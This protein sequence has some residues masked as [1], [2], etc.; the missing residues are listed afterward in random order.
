MLLEHENRELATRQVRRI[1]DTL[2]KVRKISRDSQ[3]MLRPVL[4]T[5]P[6]P[7]IPI[8]IVDSSLPSPLS[9]QRVHEVSPPYSRADTRRERDDS[10]DKFFIPE[11]QSSSIVSEVFRK[12][13]ELF[14]QECAEFKL[15]RDHNSPVVRRWKLA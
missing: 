6:T 10:T 9:F 14:E 4:E 13:F 5:T 8:S 2:R 1:N 7:E 12:A 11:P 3:R 15:S